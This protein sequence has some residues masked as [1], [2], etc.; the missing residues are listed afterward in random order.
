MSCDGFQER[1]NNSFKAHR[2][3][4]LTVLCS[5]IKGREERLKGTEAKDYF[6]TYLFQ[7]VPV[8]TMRFLCCNFVLKLLPLLFF[9]CSLCLAQELSGSLGTKKCG[10][11]QEQAR[12]ST[13]ETPKLGN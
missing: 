7:K 6:S 5:K 9:V 11:E 3:N 8:K 12:A 1:L 4:T 2:S 10:K 13:W